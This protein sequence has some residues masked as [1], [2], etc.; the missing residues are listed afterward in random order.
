MNVAGIFK[1]IEETKVSI[2]VAPLIGHNTMRSNA[3]GGWVNRPPT[4]E[5]LAKMKSLVEQA[6]KDGAVGVATGTRCAM[7]CAALPYSPCGSGAEALP[8]CPRCMSASM[9]P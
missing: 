7:P 8:R 9:M 3:M 5:E 2:N 4:D 1:R 6:M